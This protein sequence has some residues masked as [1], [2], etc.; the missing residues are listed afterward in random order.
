MNQSQFQKGNYNEW[1]NIV[2]KC[3][4]NIDT[5]LRNTFLPKLD[6]ALKSMLG[7]YT[8]FKR[9]EL[10]AYPF[11]DGNLFK[12]VYIEITYIVE[13]FHVQN[14]PDKAVSADEETLS[15]YLPEDKISISEL[16]IDTGTGKLKIKAIF[17]FN[18]TEDKE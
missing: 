16:K 3:L 17:S 7:S 11:M 9:E 10:N 15:N 6:G 2:T 13:D 4:P 12:G 18:D 5:E 14:V 1:D 8:D